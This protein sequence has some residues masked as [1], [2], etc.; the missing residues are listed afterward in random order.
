MPD[1]IAD[2]APA[3]RDR[4][5]GGDVIGL[6]RMLHAQQKTETENAEHASRLCRTD[7]KRFGAP[8]KQARHPALA[9]D[10]YAAKT[11]R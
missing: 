11:V 8:G 1:D 6:Q 9:Q 5:D 3:R 7:T 4:G 10:L 2:L